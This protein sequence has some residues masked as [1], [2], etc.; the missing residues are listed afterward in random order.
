MKVMTRS[1]VVRSDQIQRSAD[2]RK[3]LGMTNPLRIM[4]EQGDEPIIIN[5]AENSGLLND[6]NSDSYSIEDSTQAFLELAFMVKKPTDNKARKAWETKFRLLGCDAIRCQKVN[7]IVEGVV[8]KE[9]IDE[10]QELSCFQN[11][12]LDTVGLLV[13]AFEKLGKEEP[14]SDHVAVT[15]RQALLFLDNANAYFSQVHCAKI[16]KRLNPEVQSLAKDT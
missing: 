15:I 16:L 11:F 1:A 10:D 4:E 8:K 13:S 12:V 14:D 5:E 2:L 9:A 6:G 3:V 7:T